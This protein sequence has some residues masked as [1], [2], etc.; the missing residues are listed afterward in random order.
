MCTSH[1]RIQ[2]CFAALLAGV[3]G[4]KGDE[5]VESG[6]Q[7]VA[8]EVNADDAPLAQAAPT[9][10]ADKLAEE[11]GVQPGPWQADPKAGVEAAVKS[12]S[13]SLELRRLGE[14]TFADAS[15]EVVLGAGDQL[16]TGPESSATVMLADET[17]IELAEESAIAIGDRDAQAAPASQVA[18]LY[19][20][21]RFSVSPRAEGEGAFLVFTP[22]GVVGT[23]GTTYT[24][25]VAATG[26]A[27]VGV[28]EGEVAV[29][30]LADLGN[31]V[32]VSGGEAVE[33]SAEGSVAAPAA[34]AVDGWGAWRDG[35]EAA[36]EPAA[37]A[38]A[39]VEAIGELQA[40]IDG[41]YGDFEVLNTAVVEADAQA[42]VY[43]DSGDVKAY[44]AMAPDLGAT[45]EASYLASLRLEALTYAMLSRAYITGEL[46]VRHPLEVQPIYVAAAPEVHGTILYQKKLHGVVHGHVAP[47]RV[48][49][50]RHHP[51]GRVQVAAHGQ[52]VA[53]FYLK[54]QL[55]AIPAARVNER[56]GVTV[57]RPPTVVVRD[58]RRKV[59][60]VAPEANWYG[61]VKVAPARVRANWYARAK[62]PKARILAGVKVKA[63]LRPVF[64]VDAAVPRPPVVR[65]GVARPRVKA[66]MR[67]AS[68]VRIGGAVFGV[69]GAGINARGGGGGRVAVPDVRGGLNARMNAKVDAKVKGPKVRGKLD[70]KA[71]DVRGK[72]KVKAPAVRTGAKVRVDGA[73]KAGAGLRAKVKAPSV[74]VKAPSVKVGGGAKAGVKAGGDA[75][76][77]SKVKSGGG[78]KAG[79]GL[80]VKAGGGLKIGN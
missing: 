80:K 32:T 5:V 57:Y 39:Q 1:W 70:V 37:V 23:K 71:P 29:N 72:L 30:G 10:D 64:A 33:L 40:E 50:W 12:T 42:E 36:V 61:S 76:A 69:G 66:R 49:Y 56:V 21:A 75:K 79:G 25:G 63:P 62:A 77:G 44:A 9:V 51:M 53:P 31:T 13:G 14:E 58:H 24:V 35:A 60:L 55:R 68:G 65:I 78:V 27:R 34:F 26:A 17:V 3:V 52:V 59:R 11:I 20:L 48:S 47:M 41:A 2:V 43:A 73:A 74:K 38:Q 15:G 45:I 22:A 16:R 19:G 7:E 18:V 8:T 4:C 6:E 54:T 28:E 46:Y 67:V